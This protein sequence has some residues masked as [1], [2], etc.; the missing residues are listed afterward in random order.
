MEQK[1]ENFKRLIDHSFLTQVSKV[2][3]NKIN[4]ENLN[5]RK[6]TLNVKDAEFCMQQGIEVCDN[7][8][9]DNSLY[10]EYELAQVSSEI[11]RQPLASFPLLDVLSVDIQGSTASSVVY[12]IFEHKGKFVAGADK[13]TPSSIIGVNGKAEAFLIKTLNAFAEDKSILELAIGMANGIDIQSE[14]L[15]AMYEGFLKGM[16]DV[17]FEGKS[18]N[19]TFKYA[20]NNVAGATSENSASTIEQYITAGTTIKIYDEILKIVNSMKKKGKGNVELFKPNVMIVPSDL[21][22]LLDTPMQNA[23]HFHDTV[24]EYIERRFKLE[25]VPYAGFTDTA[26]FLN[27]DR[28]N[29]LVNLANPMT[30]T[31]DVEHDIIS[32]KGTTRTCGLVIRNNGAVGYLKNL[33]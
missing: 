28:R 1:T 18:G 26:I 30:T 11:V 27:T 14:L 5:I 2:V 16:H 25:I 17:I 7:K 15:M 4:E 22:G 31:T 8:I 19:A 13:A 9:V 32:V 24:R 23:G 12:K 3:S 10:V 29:L 20:L 33:A 6:K 21:D